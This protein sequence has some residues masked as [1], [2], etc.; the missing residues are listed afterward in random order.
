MVFIVVYI[1]IR[2]K[3]KKVLKKKSERWVQITCHSV[4]AHFPNQWPIDGTKPHAV[5][6]R[7]DLTLFPISS[8]PV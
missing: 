6:D 5:A 1:I 2:K 8:V 3:K 7:D 4:K